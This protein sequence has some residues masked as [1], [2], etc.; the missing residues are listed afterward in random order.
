[1]RDVICLGV[2]GNFANHLEQ[3]GEAGDFVDVEV[4]EAHAPK[5]IFPFYLP[6][7]E[8]FL[9]VYPISKDTLVLPEEEANAQVEPEIGILFGVEY[10]DR[11]RVKN[12]KA[13]KFTVFNDTTIRKEGALKI[14]EKKSWHENSKGKGDIWIDIDKFEKGGVMDR[15]RLRSFLVRDGVKHEYGV[16]APL[17]G[18]SY[19]HE[20][21][22]D[23]L[24]DKINNQKDAGPL[25]DISKHFRECG[26]PGHLFV[27]IG[28]TAYAP[29]GEQNYL[30]EGDEVIVEAYDAENPERRILLRQRVKRDQGE[31]TL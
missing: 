19:F 27:S 15:F 14:S 5:G 12:L 28:A 20:K 1:M 9:G 29:F 3:A 17:T 26:Y 31:T 11:K 7:N 8:G 13:L 25:E 10:D 18:Y 23:W 4:D 30:K 16:D 2:A 24:V 6:G 22:T 21:L